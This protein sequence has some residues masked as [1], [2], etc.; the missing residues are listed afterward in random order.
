MILENF[1]FHC[2]KIVG[3]R[4]GRYRMVFKTTKSLNGC[5]KS[6]IPTSFY[7]TSPTESRP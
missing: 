7:V 6:D 2:R 3:T 1:S 5:R 4:I